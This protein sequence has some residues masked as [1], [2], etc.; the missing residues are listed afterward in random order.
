MPSENAPAPEKPVV[1]AQVGR[2][3]TQWPSSAL[4][5]WRFS[6]GLPFSTS[7]M[8]FLLPRRSSSTAVK[9]PAGPAPTM[10]R[11]YFSI[12]LFLSFCVMM[13]GAYISVT[14]WSAGSGL[15]LSVIA[16][17]CQL[18]QRESRWPAGRLSAS[19]FG[20]NNDD[21]RQWRK[22]EIIVG[23][24]ASKTHAKRCGCWVP[25]P[26][27]WMRP[28]GADGEGKPPEVIRP[29]APPRRSRPHGP[30]PRRSPPRRRGRCPGR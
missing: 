14:V 9:I 23:A 21:R 7:R 18:S 28:A 13:F 25:Q 27:Q 17:Q 26:G 3:L 11:S 1:M 29:P 20:S 24:A 6:T 2:Q 22:Q 30:A 12:A 15:A 4:G 19:P 10:M 5:Q 8:C 16:S